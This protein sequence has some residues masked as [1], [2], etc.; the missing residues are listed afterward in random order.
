MLNIQKLS[1][2]MLRNTCDP[3]KLNF[4]STS[5]LQPLKGLI[6]QERAVKAMEFGLK[7]KTRG[8]NLYMSGLTGTGKT[9]YAHNYIKKVAMEAKTPDD[10]C[11]LHNFEKA[12]QPVAVNLPAGLGKTFLRDIED[13]IKILKTEI[14]RVFDSE[15][16][17]KGKTDIIK[18]FEDKRSDLMEKLSD[19]A[20][21]KGFKIKTTTGG[22]YFVPVMEGKPLSEQEFGQLDDATRQTISEKSTQVQKETMEMIRKIK[23]IEKD[24]EEK[25]G[26]W[27]T[28]TVL[29]ALGVHIND[30]K[31]KYKDY[32]KITFFLD[33]VQEDI[34][35][36]LD[37]FID[38]EG[39]DKSQPALPWATK[40]NASPADK[41]AVNL[42]VDNSGKTGAP[43]VVDF[44]PTYYN[45]LG[46]L[47][48][49]N[50]FGTVTTDFTMI[51][52]G[53]FHQANGGYLI[54]QA[55]D[56]LTNTMS[57]ELLKRAIRTKVINIENMKEQLGL[58]PVSV[59]KPEPIPLDIKVILV[60]SEYLY[61]LLYQMDEDFSKL[62]KIKVDFDDVMDRTMDNI[63]K[64]G[65]F[66]SSFCENEG[67]IHFHKNAV[68]KIVE[69]SSRIVEEQD[70]MTTRF[71]D[72]VDILSESSAWAGVEGARLVQARHVDKA[73]REKKHRSDKYDQRLLKLLTD[74]TILVDTEGEAV[75]Q[76][77]GLSI[78]D[79]G[80]YMF[81]KPSRITATTYMGKSGIVNIEREIEM[82]GTSH[83]KGVMI[84]SGYLGSRYAQEMPMSLTASLCFEQLYS[85]VDGDSASSTELYAI[86]S[87][88]SEAPI[89]QGIAVTGSV[90][91]KGEIQPIGG[92]THKIEG[93]FELCRMRGLTGSQGVIIPHQNV[94]NLVLNDEVIQAVKEGQFHIYAIHHIDEGIEILTGKKAGV[95]NADGTYPEGTINQLVHEKLRRFAQTC[96]GFGKK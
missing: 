93:F 18:E 2:D 49:E 6:G 90:N 5:E 41:Y 71:N 53:L 86:L 35:Q 8:Y 13:F 11:Y 85:G 20:Q 7:V 54:L 75:G 15:D 16:Y 34:L 79:M 25:V 33:K 29:L 63:E 84:L 96:A 95:C 87:S 46:R 32:T 43:V 89:R 19:D 74:G 42:L 52:G 51:K 45:L 3:A 62:F 10:W 22:I 60:G 4:E 12:N 68:A 67:A 69:Y 70:K 65:H 78:L 81:G 1:H 72:I 64:L 58:M 21:E 14:P 56:V 66:I 37:G 17:E 47:E 91:Q 30:L 44:N 40:T 94:K 27:E 36:N 48:Y 82:S 61:Q 24:A 50:D 38:N 92:A 73:I 59:L 9:S 76:I 28:K 31:D 80:D 88:L 57:W 26:Q 23:S 83:S 77:N 39:P 55:K